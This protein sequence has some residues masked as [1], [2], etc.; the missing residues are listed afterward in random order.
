[1]SHWS[2]W[3][4]ASTRPAATVREQH[5]P[6]SHLREAGRPAAAALRLGPSFARTLHHPKSRG[7]SYVFYDHTYALSQPG[8][9]DNDTAHRRRPRP[10]PGV[11]RRAR[12]AGPAGALRPRRH[13]AGHH[14]AWELYRYDS[15]LRE[16]RTCSP[17]DHDKPWARDADAAAA[18]VGRLRSGAVPGRDAL[19]S[20]ARQAER[21][22]RGSA[23]GPVRRTTDD[24]G[25]AS[26]TARP[27]RSWPIPSIT[28]S[29]APGIARAVA[30]PPETCTILS[31]AAVHHRGRDPQRG[32]GPRTVGL[33]EDASIWRI[34]PLAETPRSKVSLGT[35]RAPS[36]SVAEA[37]RADQLPH[38]RRGVT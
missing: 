20:G 11:H 1:M 6:G 31:A 25:V 37:G 15:A 5:G 2:S 22:R 19:R 4:P 18:D 36:S 17:S 14:Y 8:E 26:R 3:V 38:L 7:G 35:A 33:V 9:V 10:D 23:R 13:L 21:S 12:Q 34:T 27:G 30:R 32:E 16:D 29:S 24:V 28:S